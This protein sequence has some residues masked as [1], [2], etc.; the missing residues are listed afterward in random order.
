MSG[1]DDAQDEFDDSD[2][3][4][5]YSGLAM[6]RNNIETGNPHL[7]A[8][9]AAH[10]KDVAIKPLSIS[11]MKLVIRIDELMQAALDRRI[12]IRPVKTW[13]QADAT[14]ADATPTDDL[15]L[16]SDNCKCWGCTDHGR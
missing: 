1:N 2:A 8:V 4:I 9:D 12:S 16:H 5:I 6:R 11:Q 15:R 14:K 10:R 3:G 13:K 7:S